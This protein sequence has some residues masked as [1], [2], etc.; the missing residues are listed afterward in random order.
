MTAGSQRIYLVGGGP[1]TVRALRAHF[2]T[3]IEEIGVPRPLVAYVG[4]AS[5][6]NAGFEKMLT[7]ELTSTGARFKPARLASP[8]SSVAAA[9]KLL[10]ECDLV[11]F[12]G[13]D[14]DLGM[15]LLAERGVLED[16]RSLCRDG[17]PMFGLSAGSVMLGRE[18]VRFPDDDDA[19]AEIFE[20]IGAVPFHADAHSEDDD[21]S[22]LRVLLGL[23][24][25]RGDKGMVGYGLMA[26]GGLSVEI[27]GKEVSMRAM[28]TDIPRLLVRAGK[29]VHDKPL[30]CRV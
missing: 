16:V 22:E 29:V 6:D 23:L 25:K 27:R 20:C 24:H 26:K 9:K 7:T 30:V 17:K 21:W 14:V 8:T 4:V 1:G 18:W 5:E 15:R 12:S 3:A 2:R 13:G 19:R 10:H 28:G 11:F